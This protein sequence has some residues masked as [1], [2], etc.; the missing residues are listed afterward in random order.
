[1]GR[2][3]AGKSSLINKLTGQDSALVSPVAGTTTDPVYKAMEL[4]PL[5]PVV[6]IDTAGIDD[7]GDLGKQ[8]VFK[9][10]R[11]LSKTD[12]ALLVTDAS[13][14]F[15]SYEK[16]MITRFKELNIPFAF[17]LNKSDLGLSPSMQKI[18]ETA[19]YPVL[20]V[21]CTNGSGITEL[22]NKLPRLVP[23]EQSPP[24]VGDLIGG[25]E[26]LV[27]VTPIDLGAPKGRLILPQVQTIR[28]A[29]DQDAVITVT[30]E[31]E[32]PYTLD[33]FKTPPRL[34]VTDSQVIMKVI[35]DVPEEILL[36]TFSILMA[37]YKGDLPTLVKG[38]AAVENLRNGDRVLIAEACTHHAQEDDI[39]S[40]KIPRWL[41]NHVGADI[42]ID[43]VNGF[44]FPEEV[45]KYKLVIHCGS[46]MLNRRAMLFRIRQVAR[47]NIP[48]VNY[49]VIISYLHGAIPRV[50]KPFP[51]I[52]ALYQEL[53]DKT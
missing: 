49:G 18:S 34:V 38:L 16:E 13:R 52:F 46:C 43:H 12:F 41:R 44:D 4:L 40:V 45:E 53:I 26:H 11:V 47:L 15:S 1:M 23:T 5:G 33:M 29:L 35:A 30:K 22:K 19:D 2:R 31:R 7:E 24:L 28:E 10:Y 17:I 51:E 32:L 8:R 39:G 25:G 14:E 27:L 20:T 42:H 9:S 21:S 48:I 37:R 36:T 3:N 6:L 50:L